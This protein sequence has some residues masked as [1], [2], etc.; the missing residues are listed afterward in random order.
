[1]K[2]R[3]FTVMV[4]L[5]NNKLSKKDNCPIINLELGCMKLILLQN[6]CIK[7]FFLIKSYNF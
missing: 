1:M 7:S 3:N 2:Q 4:T 6:T 5:E